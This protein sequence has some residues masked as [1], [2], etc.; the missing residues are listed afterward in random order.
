MH[1][2]L[3]DGELETHVT[4][5]EARAGSSTKVNR[6]VLGISLPLV[7]VALAI[8]TAVGFWI[9]DRSGADDVNAN[10]GAVASGEN[11]TAD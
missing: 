7:I 6:N 1:D 9:T 5:K 4:H 11:I 8:A 2:E 3:R 10:N